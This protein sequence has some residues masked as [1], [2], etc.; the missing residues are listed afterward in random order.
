M[1]TPLPSS[2]LPDPRAPAS[3]HPG[4]SSAGMVFTVFSGLALRGFGGVLPFAQR[5]LVEERGWMSNDEFAETLSLA[6]VLPGP[7]ICNLAL[8]VGDRF[9]GIRGAFAALAGMLA[10]PLVLVV[11]LA[12]LY[13]GFADQPIVTRMLAGMSA[14]S[15]GLVLAMALKLSAA[16]RRR[17]LTWLFVAA[18]FLMVGVLRW[19][20][21]Q[22]LLGLG[23][24]SM[25]LAWRRHAP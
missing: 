5:A 9:F 1:T 21:W 3:P 8:M 18:A 23:S 7:N 16:Q 17:P 11:T 14:V 10:L 12:A 20:L 15:A 6:Q 25:L 2:D 22:V 4:P 19:P 13:S 24:V